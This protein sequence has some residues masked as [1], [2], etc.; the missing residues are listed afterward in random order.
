ME[1]L[2]GAP[3]KLYGALYANF[4][5]RNVMEISMDF[6]TRDIMCVF[7]YWSGPVRTDTKSIRLLLVRLESDRS[8]VGPGRNRFFTR[9]DRF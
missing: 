9:P 2:Y 7:V 8:I 3:Q 4:L 5:W 1:N 6:S